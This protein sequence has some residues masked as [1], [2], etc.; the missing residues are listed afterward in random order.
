MLKEFYEKL[1]TIHYDSKSDKL[2]ELIDQIYNRNSSEKIIIFTQFVDT[3]LFLRDLLKNHSNNY[4]VEI[5]YGKMDKNEKDEA[6]ER[7]RTNKNFSILIST[8]IGGEGR[9]FQFC[10]ILI[11]YDLPWNPMRLE[12][13]IGRL[14]R[15]GQQS[16]EIYIYNLFLEGTIETDII[17]A[18]NKRINLFEESI[19]TLEPIIGTIEK[20]IRD[21][22]FLEANKPRQRT[23]MNEFIRNVED[24]IKKTK[25]I[26]LQLEDLMIDKKSFQMD[27]LLT[28]IASCEEVKL[29]HNELFLFM[30]Y[31]FDLNNH[32]YGY[33]ETIDGSSEVPKSR[34]MI[35]LNENLMNVLNHHISKDSIGTFDLEL[36]R[37]REEIEF[38]ALGHPLVDNIL[39]F[40]TSNPFKGKYTIINLKKEILSTTLKFTLLSHTQYYLF[41]FDVKFQGFIVENQISGIIVDESGHEINVLSDFILNI[42]NF[43]LLFKCTQDQSPKIR[44]EKDKLEILVQNAKNLVKSRISGWKKEIKILNDRIFDI[45]LKKK[46]KIYSH[47]QKVLTYKSATLK[48]NLERK[49]NQKPSEKQLNN[50]FSIEDET[51]RKEKL[52]R[53][54]DLDEEIK[55]IK[56]DI[57]EIKKKMDDLAFEHEDV[58]NEMIKKNLAKFYTNLLGIAIIRIMD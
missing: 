4:Y 30:K 54:K 31:F 39:D 34:I 14:D 55:F 8:E 25:E 10:R 51:K 41:I 44:V 38:F 23:K 33:F 37:E 28:S 1:N 50:I 56:K 40:C 32:E 7:F 6:V 24:D 19:G 22:I 11:N 42:K 49:I 58:K 29:S 16:R 5:F 57:D 45:E 3:L 53:I 47:K 9:N 26:E 17:F 43:D 13:R 46:N 27:G 35:K 15:I 20:D 12:Q 18:L 2:I 48:L 52:D 21:I 36:A